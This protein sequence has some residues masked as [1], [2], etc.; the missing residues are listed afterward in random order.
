MFGLSTRCEC[1]I[2][3]LN[4]SSPEPNGEDPKF[5][6]LARPKA[7][8]CRLR[9]ASEGKAVFFGNDDGGD[10]RPNFDGTEAATGPCLAMYEMP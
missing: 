6:A 2:R 4:P 7:E 9:M 8:S 1:M 3:W 5:D 10:S